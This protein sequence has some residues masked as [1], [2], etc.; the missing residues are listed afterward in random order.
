MVQLQIRAKKI[1]EECNV[2]V[3]SKMYAFQGTSMKTLIN[4]FLPHFDDI[5]AFISL[6]Q[7]EILH[8]FNSTRIF[9]RNLG[10]A[11]PKK[12]VRLLRIELNSD[13]STCQRTVKKTATVFRNNEISPQM[14]NEIRKRYEFECS[15]TADLV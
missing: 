7:D 14:R 11:L 9:F 8:A 3:R 4:I 12:S 15:L 10:R 5:S 13:R 6:R 1:L 2:S